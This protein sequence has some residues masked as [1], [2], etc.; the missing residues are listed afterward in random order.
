MIVRLPGCSP[1]VVDLFT[2]SVTRVGPET[3]GAIF[4]VAAGHCDDG[5]MSMQS[6]LEV[7]TTPRRSQRLVIR[8]FLTGALVIG[9]LIGL[10]YTFS[11]TQTKVENKYPVHLESVTPE[12]SS[13][14]V[15]SQST[16]SA[17]LEFGYTGVLIVN[18]REIPQDQLVEVPAT[19]QLSFSPG[20]GKEFSRLPGG[21][22]RVTVAFWPTQGS[23]EADVDSHTWVM[24][25]N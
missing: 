22:V 8:R 1:V 24:N 4:L 19:G 23:R 18:G 21:L 2:A 6:Q 14:N 15:P 5:S 20:A 7:G 12:N 16:I 17:D 11:S 25:V 9:S 10:I 13:Q 3:V